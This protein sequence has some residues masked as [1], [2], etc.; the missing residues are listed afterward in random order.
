MNN[1]RQN[2][3]VPPRA[4]SQC[5]NRSNKWGAILISLTHIYISTIL[6]EN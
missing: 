3:S 1:I 6:T 4:Y 2:A 5:S